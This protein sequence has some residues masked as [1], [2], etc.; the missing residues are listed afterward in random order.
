MTLRS[1]ARSTLLLA[2]PSLS[3]ALTLDCQL[4]PTAI[5]RGA[6]TERY[7]IQHDEGS[8][9]AI[10]SDG[11]ILYYNDS[12]PMT[13]KVSEDSGKKLVVTWNVQI[14]NKTGQMTKMQYRA[15]WFKAD[16]NVIIRAVPG[17]YSNDFEA[18]GTCKKV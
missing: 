13:A 15:S 6:I 1:L 2:I 5:A 8:A 9:Q 7:V 3:H 18:R 17:G 16:G 11:V 14:T 12:Q 4:T 10:V